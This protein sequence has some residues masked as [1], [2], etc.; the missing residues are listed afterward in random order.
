LHNPK[1]Q[2]ILGDDIR[3]LTAF[4]HKRIRCD[5]SLIYSPVNRRSIGSILNTESTRGSMRVLLRYTQQC[6]GMYKISQ[7]ARF[8]QYTLEVAGHNKYTMEPINNDL[9][10]KSYMH[11][12]H[13]SRHPISS[14][15]STTFL[16]ILS[17]LR[18]HTIHTRSCH[19]AAYDISGR[20]CKREK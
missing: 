13:H 2:D 14:H 10:L 7:N 19:V 12:H 3:G 18:A 16:F 8:T 9:V 11:K 4:Y 20:Y 17:L 5:C 1:L 6:Y 15:V